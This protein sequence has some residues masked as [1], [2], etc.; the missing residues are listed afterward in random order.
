MILILRLWALIN[1]T[2]MPPQCHFLL[3]GPNLSH[4]LTPTSAT[5]DGSDLATAISVGAYHGGSLA[6]FEL[7]YFVVWLV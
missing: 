5:C 7:K 3:M 1:T 4:P 6:W 2:T